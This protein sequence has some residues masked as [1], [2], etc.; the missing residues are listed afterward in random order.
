MFCSLLFVECLI[1]ASAG[2]L[3]GFKFAILDCKQ[4]L[5]SDTTWI[6]N[7]TTFVKEGIRITNDSNINLAGNENLKIMITRNEY[8]INYQCEISPLKDYVREFPLKGGYLCIF[9]SG[10]KSGYITV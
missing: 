4:P 3:C 10:T 8:C 5:D 9:L 6:G 2:E 7:R 1:D